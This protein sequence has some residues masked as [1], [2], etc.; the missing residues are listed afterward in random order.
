M[1]PGT[2]FTRTNRLKIAR[3]FFTAMVFRFVLLLAAD[4]LL[5]IKFFFHT[6][7]A[8]GIH[9]FLLL[10]YEGK[11]KRKEPLS[12]VLEISAKAPSFFEGAGQIN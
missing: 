3:A 9:S 11:R 10:I 6:I 12:I 8:H 5:V 1:F 7:L 2:L 4:F